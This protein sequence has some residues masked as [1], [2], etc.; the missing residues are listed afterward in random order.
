MSRRGVPL[1]L[2]MADPGRVVARLPKP[3]DSDTPEQRFFR[4]FQEVS[5]AMRSD[6]RPTLRERTALRDRIRQAADRYITEVLAE[7]GTEPLHE[8]Q[9]RRK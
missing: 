3:S 5:S 9:P 8:A 6:P 1:N 2:A 7:S 4:T